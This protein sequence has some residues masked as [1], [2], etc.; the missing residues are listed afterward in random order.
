[1]HALKFPKAEFLTLQLFSM[2]AALMIPNAASVRP[3]W[4]VFSDLCTAFSE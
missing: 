3:D 4:T 1:M 2:L